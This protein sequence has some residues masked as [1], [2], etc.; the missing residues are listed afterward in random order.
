VAFDHARRAFRRRGGRQQTGSAPRSTG[1][2]K[3]LG[4]AGRSSRAITI[5]SRSPRPSRR[6][7]R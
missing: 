4:G 1:R 5:G 3:L 6:P 7:H 2:R